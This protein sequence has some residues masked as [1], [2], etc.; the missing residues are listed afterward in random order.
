MALLSLASLAGT[1]SGDGDSYVK[2]P[3]SIYKVGYFF[4]GWTTFIGRCEGFCHVRTVGMA[5]TD[6][7]VGKKP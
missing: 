4:R 6:L 7:S 5:T 2:L 1:C 3:F